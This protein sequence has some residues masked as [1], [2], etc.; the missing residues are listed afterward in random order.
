MIKYEIKLI[1][2]RDFELSIFKAHDIEKLRKILRS[3]RN[4]HLKIK[5]YNHKFILNINFFNYCS[6]TQKEV[7]NAKRFSIFKKL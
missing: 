6:I 5:S 7:I 1:E 2:N 3:L 4:F